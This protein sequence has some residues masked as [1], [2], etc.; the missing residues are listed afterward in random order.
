MNYSNPLKAFSIYNPQPDKKKQIQHISEHLLCQCSHVD[1]HL[2]YIIV[3]KPAKNLFQGKLEFCLLRSHSGKN[4]CLDLM[5]H[6]SEIFSLS[7]LQ[8]ALDRFL[9]NKTNFKHLKF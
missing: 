1:E 3:R 4:F 6:S 2:D 8:S 9:P 5:F 7:I